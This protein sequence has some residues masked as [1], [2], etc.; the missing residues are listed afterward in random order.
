MYYISP[1][2]IETF[3]QIN[4]TK[5]VCVSCWPSNNS[6]TASGRHSGRRDCR[7]R[8]L[9]GTNVLC[10]LSGRRRSCRRIRLN[11]RRRICLSIR[12]R[13]KQHWK[14]TDQA[15]SPRSYSI[16]QQLNHHTSYVIRMQSRHRRMIYYKS[17]TCAWLHKLYKFAATGYVPSLQDSS[18][19][20]PLDN[21]TNDHKLC[22]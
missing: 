5:S 14:Q 15:L 22:I 6:T 21:S 17:H 1:C 12:L 16:S 4:K 13:I 2:W 7:G 3:K 9:L 19:A 8:A 18:V 10:E 20:C 11:G